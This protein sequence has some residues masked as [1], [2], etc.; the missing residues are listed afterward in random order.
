MTLLAPTYIKKLPIYDGW[1]NRVPRFQRQSRHAY[2][3][4]SFGADRTETTTATSAASA[5]VTDNFDCDII[6]V[7]RLFRAVSGR[8]AVAVATRQHGS[9]ANG[10][11]RRR[12]FHFVGLLRELFLAHHRVHA[13]VEPLVRGVASR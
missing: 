12:P 1:D 8:R 5:A 9:E 3:V 11:P 6:Y 2:M 4:K 13:R 10:R 7:E